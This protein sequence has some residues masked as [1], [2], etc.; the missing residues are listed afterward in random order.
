VLG[1]GVDA[2][3]LNQLV[4]ELEDEAVLAKRREKTRTRRR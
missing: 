4:D 2:S 1:P 3:A